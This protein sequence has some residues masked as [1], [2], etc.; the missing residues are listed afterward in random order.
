HEVV[1]ARIQ[2]ADEAEHTFEAYTS[3]AAIFKNQ[4]RQMI[5]QTIVH[6][7]LDKYLREL[8]PTERESPGEK[9]RQNEK[10]DPM[11]LKRRIAEHLERT[12]FFWRLYPGLLSHRFK[13]L[14][15]L[16]P[17]KRVFCFPAAA[18]GFLGALVSS[19]AAHRFLK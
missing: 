5:G 14:A 18:V 4:K 13:R 16:S 2:V 10:A 15:R 19:F 3:P 8:P 9:L 1:P 7:L 11:W 12:R 6:I 17:A